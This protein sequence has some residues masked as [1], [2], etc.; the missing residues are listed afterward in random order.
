MISKIKNCPKCWGGR[1]LTIAGRIQIFKT[2]A[3]GGGGGGEGRRNYLG[4][5]ISRSYMRYLL[6][7]IL[8]RRDYLGFDVSSM[9][10]SK[11]F[12]SINTRQL[13]IW[14]L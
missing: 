1:G 4:S 3:S 13:I 7:E 8:G 14:G 9:P 2:L 6:F 5:E 11:P 10:L 12:F